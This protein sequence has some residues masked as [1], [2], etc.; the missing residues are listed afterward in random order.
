MRPLCYSIN[1][2]IDGCADHMA[3]IPTE[4]LHH[5]SAEII[6]RADTLILGRT[7][8]QMMESAW[9]EQ[10]ATS[11]LPE[12]RPD[13]TMPFARTIHAAKKFVVS[14]TLQSVDWNAEIIRGKDLEKTIRRLKEQPGKGLYTAGLTLPLSL[15]EL[16][17]I[18]EFEFV[19]HPR[20]AGHGPTPFAGLSKFI[21][22]NLSSCRQFPS[23]MMSLRYKRK[24]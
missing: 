6:G 20:L 1:I 18:D 23:G 21:D 22:L 2:T 4:E 17:L 14:D 5:Y 9:R 7:I 13:W 3:A 24:V 15:A 10:G 16:G 19:V 11:R 12:G 8:Y